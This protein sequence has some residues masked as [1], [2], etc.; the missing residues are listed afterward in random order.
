MARRAV[1]LMTKSTAKR[2]PPGQSLNRVFNSGASFRC[3]GGHARN[4]VI[5]FL[6]LTPAMWKRYHV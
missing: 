5:E 2:G 3:G 6:R 1:L 4:R